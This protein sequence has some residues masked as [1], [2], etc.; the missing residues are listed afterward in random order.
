MTLTRLMLQAFSKP[1]VVSGGGS[2]G[3]AYESTGAGN[4]TTTTAVTTL[5]ETH[6][7]GVAVTALLVSV[8]GF[9]DVTTSYTGVTPRT[10]TV[11]STPMT[12][13][14]V[15]DANNSAGKGWVEVF[16]LINP[17][18]GFQTITFTAGTAVFCSMNSVAYSGVSSFGTA[19]TNSGNTATASSGAIT[20]ATGDRVFSALC[21]IVSQFLLT[22]SGTQRYVYP[23]VSTTNMPG[24]MIQDAAGAA[25]VTITAA[26]SGGVHSWGGVSLNLAA[27]PVVPGA[28][29]APWVDEDVGAPALAGSA[30]YTGGV[31]TVNGAGTDIWAGAD[32][33]NFVHRSLTG[34]GSITARV[35]T[36]TNTDVWA[37]S[38]V[39]IKQSTTSATP[40]ALAAYTAGN[41]TVLQAN[42][43]ENTQV[44]GNALP[45]SWVRLTRIGT[46]VTGYT[47]PDGVTWTAIASTTVS[48]GSAAEFGIFVCSHNAAALCASTF[49]NVA[50]STIVPGVPTITSI[51][52]P[53][54]GAGGLITINGT[55]FVTGAT[56]KFDATSATGVTVVSGIQITCTAPAHATGASVVT[57]TTSGGTSAGATFTYVASVAASVTDDST[58]LFL[59]GSAGSTSFTDDGTGL[60]NIIG[61][62]TVALTDDGTGLFIMS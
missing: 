6:T 21:D 59:I 51:S 29:P 38:G 54:G 17:P 60:F 32:Q 16:G 12:S 55:N 34:D 30:T 46:T 28:L 39:M 2:G 41:Q 11:G 50:V 56:V 52:P 13:L 15:I 27:A 37:K 7:I 31:F 49:D 26:C 14:G 20:S 53:S 24:H 5:A 45:N 44:A 18:T 43:A 3:L 36:Q 9:K 48:L 1:T 47:S 57:V 35:L 42:F 62:G 8:A 40:Y 22:P 10:V 58:G 25:S 61:S 19:A 4:A 33:F 23:T